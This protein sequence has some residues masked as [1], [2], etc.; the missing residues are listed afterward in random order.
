MCTDPHF[1]KGRCCI[2]VFVADRQ[3]QRREAVH[4]GGLQQGRLPLLLSQ[5]PLLLQPHL[6]LPP[7]ALP[8]PPLLP[9]PQPPRRRGAA[10]GWAAGLPIRGCRG[11][12]ALE[13][14]V[15]L[16]RLQAGAH[17]RGAAVQRG[18]VERIVAAPAVG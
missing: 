7:H 6:P 8:P 1:N 14:R 11:G 13:Q 12:C 3:V 5:P 4:V 9:A 18:V 15:G 16:S 2:H 17:A 10:S